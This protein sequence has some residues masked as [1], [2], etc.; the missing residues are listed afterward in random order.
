MRLRL[1]LVIRIL[2]LL[3]SR[4]LVVG[5]AR[6]RAF[7]LHQCLR[8]EKLGVVEGSE[9]AQPLLDSGRQECFFCAEAKGVIRQRHG[10]KHL[11][12]AADDRDALL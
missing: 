4:L 1:C 10:A 7:R 8:G 6:V 3:G 5:A 12:N 11:G 9:E 2:D